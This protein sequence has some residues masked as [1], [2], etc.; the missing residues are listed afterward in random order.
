ME[1]DCTTAVLLRGCIPLDTKR[2][3]S[4]DVPSLRRQVEPRAPPN[5]GWV[6]GVCTRRWRTEANNSQF[7][8]VPL[9]GQR[10]SPHL[11]LQ[12]AM[13]ARFEKE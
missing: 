6:T 5:Q 9:S 1:I 11:P 3:L 10:T 13:S 2:C 4:N 12:A 7:I 8:N